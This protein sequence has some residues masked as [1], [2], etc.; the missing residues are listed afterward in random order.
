MQLTGRQAEDREIIRGQLHPD[1]SFDLVARDIVIG[2]RPASFYF[3]DGFMKDGV[4]EKVLQFLIGL[5]ADQLQTT[6]DMDQFAQRFMPYVEAD[7][8][9]DVDKMIT[10]VL[11]GQ[12]LILIDGMP[13][14]L[15]VDA[16]TYPMR[17]VEPPE[18]EKV[19]RGSRDGF[20]ETLVMNTAM[21]RRRIRD[22][23]LRV[24]HMQVGGMSRVDVALVYI[25]GLAHPQEV[26]KVRK[27]LQSI[28]VDSVSMTQ[29]AI[30]EAAVD[31]HWINPFPKVKFSERPDYTAA[32]VMEGRIA[33]VIDNS[34][35]VMI[36]PVCF[37]DFM[38]E[39]DDYYFPPLTS[40]YLKIARILI[41]LMTVFLPPIFLYL[42]NHEEL[43]PP[44]FEFI[45]IVEPVVMPVLAQFLL[46]ELVIDTL[47]LASTNTPNMMS[48]A[49]GIIGGLL[50][51]DFAIQSGWFAAEIILYM[52]FVAISSYAQPSFEMGYAFKFFRVLMLILTQL[53]GLWGLL[54][55]AILM[56]I[57][58]IC[59]E[60][61]TGKGYFYPIIPFNATDFRKMFIRR[62]LKNSK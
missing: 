23:A 44:S 40:S 38:K 18:K 53:F 46:L 41:S 19:L 54:G 7:V 2:E 10:G 15:L 21:I 5:T 58:L 12:T 11:S 42:L 37:A 52:A 49:M 48:N 61:F 59:T 34:P 27:K 36:L 45:K 1:E 24:Q 9:P 60:T 20:V 14:G 17:G 4:F 33:V 28:R 55:G 39:A 22:C 6:P 3:V 29:E 26:E 43:I 30:C 8:E 13:D 50:L 32:C 16:R 25:D 51:S 57:S 56:L 62:K 35:S 31:Y 47:R